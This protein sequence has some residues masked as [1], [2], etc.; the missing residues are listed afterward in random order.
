M[1]RQKQEPSK[2]DKT[3]HDDTISKSIRIIAILVPILMVVLIVAA[4]SIS[5]LVILTIISL[6]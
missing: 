1:C 5:T 4:L 3:E 2:V 6:K